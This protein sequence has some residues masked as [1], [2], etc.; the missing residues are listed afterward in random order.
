MKR[1]ELS[2]IDEEFGGEEPS[3]EKRLLDELRNSLELE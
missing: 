3:Q 1:Y 2:D